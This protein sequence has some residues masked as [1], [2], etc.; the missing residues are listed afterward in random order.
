[1]HLV[2]LMAG[3]KASKRRLDTVREPLQPSTVKQVGAAVALA[4]GVASPLA[5]QA[6]ELALLWR[7]AGSTLAVP[8]PLERGPTAVFW[9]PA[10]VYEAAG[11]SAGLEVLHASDVVSLSGLLGAVAYRLGDVASI[12]I[13]GGR[14]SVANLVRTTT[15]PVSEE[16]DI[17]VYAQ[18]VGVGAGTGIG[19]LTAGAQVR[20]HD[21][22]LDTRAE[23]GVTVDVGVH[24]RPTSALTIGAASQ[25]GY[26]DLAGR[27]TTGYFGAAEYR[28]VAGPVWGAPAFIIGRY[29]VEV[30]NSGVPGHVDVEHVVSAGLSLAARLRVDLAL[31]RESAYGAGEWRPV[32]GI[33]FRA[34]R[35]LVAVARGNG[36]NDVG[37]TYRI[38]LSAGASP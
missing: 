1:M 3:E 20:F 8:A 9:N 16:G 11:L 34:G 38:G 4:L 26:V 17:P 37:A 32:L 21:T 22:R 5:A 18:F 14:M 6:P 31:R 33:S 10:A 15:S 35:Y 36:L 2:N 29:G 28:A 24:V 30:R 23:N 19:P 25:F 7:V 27:A 13:S 12:G